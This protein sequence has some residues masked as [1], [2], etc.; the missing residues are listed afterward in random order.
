MKKN[1]IAEIERLIEKYK[2]R[3]RVIRTKTF[4]TGSEYSEINTLA[5]VIKDL[6]AILN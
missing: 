3:I 2:E 5:V 6:E 1:K 4:I